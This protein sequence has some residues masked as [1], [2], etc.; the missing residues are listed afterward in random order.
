MAVAESDPMVTHWLRSLENGDPDAAARLWAEYFE[1]LVEVARQKIGVQTRRTVDG[2]DVALSVLD[3]L[4]RGAAEG[5]FQQLQDR[6]QLWFLL[7]AITKDKAIS[8]NRREAAQKRGSGQ[9][10]DGASLG[11][12]SRSR[13][14]LTFDDICGEFPTPDFIVELADQHRHLM[15][16]L[17]NNALRQIASD[18]MEGYTTTEIANRLSTSVRTVQR[19][20]RLIAGIWS[21]VLSQKFTT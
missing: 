3:T 11:V 7:L 8:R 21:D 17:P 16:L 4:I 6:R 9:V 13:V 1:R 18:I 15:E 12:R 5:R 14:E 20:I 10:V 19:K 2:E